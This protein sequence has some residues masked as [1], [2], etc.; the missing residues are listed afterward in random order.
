MSD[1]LS[2]RG[3]VHPFTGGITAYAH[4]SI[5]LFNH[6]CVLGYPGAKLRGRGAMPVSRGEQADTDGDCC[7]DFSAIE[8]QM[9]R[10]V[11]RDGSYGPNTQQECE[12]KNAQFQQSYQQV[13]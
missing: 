7:S 3:L 1:Q 12:E 9:R 2:L 6:F 5:A 8:Y 4:T 10:K 13:G 11:K